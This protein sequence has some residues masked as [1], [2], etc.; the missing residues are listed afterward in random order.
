MWVIFLSVVEVDDRGRMTIPKE[1]G[2][3]GARAAIIPA[4]S[5]LVIVPIT[6]DPYKVAGSWL[7]A[8]RDAK[9]LKGE[10]DS[11]AAEDAVGRARRRRQI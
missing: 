4:G 1:L 6:G 8:E 2:L 10:A 9:A 5:F 7:H 11:K 3:R